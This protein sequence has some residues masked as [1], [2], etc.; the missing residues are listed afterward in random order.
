[1]SFSISLGA[2]RIW[3]R[4]PGWRLEVIHQ[5]C[6]RILDASRVSWEKKGIWSHLED[7]LD[8]L[9]NVLG[10]WDKFFEN[11]VIF[12]L[13]NPPLKRWSEMAL[14]VDQGLSVWKVYEMIW[15]SQWLGLSI[16]W[17]PEKHQRESDHRYHNT[18]EIFKPIGFPQVLKCVGH[19]PQ[20]LKCVGHMTWRI[21]I[22]ASQTISACILRSWEMDWEWA[23]R[24]MQGLIGNA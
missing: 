17:H 15:S 24:G 13:I 11:G 5:Y 19:F 4:F 6:N 20:V 9:K 3:I 18:R 14:W 7:N 16:Q 12:S 21:L 1:M 10:N 23:E 8:V 22:M 2:V